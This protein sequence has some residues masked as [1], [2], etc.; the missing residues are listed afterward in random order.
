MHR[1]QR[2]HR[3]LEDHRRHPAANIVQRVGL[4]LQ[5]GDIDV[6]LAFGAEDDFS[7]EDFA[8][9]L[10]KAEN[11][12]GCHALAAPALANDRKRLAP[13]HRERHAVNGWQYALDGGED[14][15]E[16]TDLQDAVTLIDGLGGHRLVPPCRRLLGG[17]RIFLD[18]LVHGTLRSPGGIG[19]RG[20]TQ[21]VAQEIEAQYSRYDEHHR[22]KQPG[23]DADGFDVA[24]VLEHHAP[25][26]D[27]GAQ[28]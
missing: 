4:L 9:L 26:D 6:S 23:V 7:V 17:G 25:A 8:G 19:V 2:G 1:A 21:P 16:V 5:G 10:D 15:L 12:V 24:A 13:R 20:V 27:R 14:R 3:F 22:Q 11:R 18:C 28:A